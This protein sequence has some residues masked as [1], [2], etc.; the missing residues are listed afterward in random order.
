MKRMAKWKRILFWTL[1]GLLAVVCVLVVIVLRNL[2]PLAV[3]IGEAR[4]RAIATEAINRAVAETMSGVRY[5][6]LIDIE[7]DQNGQ[8]SYLRANA[9]YM[10]QLATQAAIS[11]Q[12]QISA[13]ELRPLQIAL[14]SALG[15]P[16]FSGRGPTIPVKVELAGSVVSDFCS[17]FTSAGINQTRHMIYL[18][19][20]AALRILIPT[21]GQT[22]Q[23]TVQVPVTETIIVGTVPESFIDVNDKEDMLNLIPDY[24]Q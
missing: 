10:N 1:G 20:H 2:T 15:S 23:V 16:L 9:V 5:E 17:E 3:S 11:A 13:I 21:G 12:Q 7:T 18:R 8:V 24:A 19:L 22:V 6:D 4:L 14:G